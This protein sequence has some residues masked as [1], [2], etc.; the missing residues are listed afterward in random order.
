[1]FALLPVLLCEMP[2][3]DIFW[4]EHLAVLKGLERYHKKRA[5]LRA[6]A[7]LCRSLHAKRLYH[8]DLKAANLLFS[9]GAAPPDGVFNVIDLQGCGC[10]LMSACGAESKTWHN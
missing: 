4:Q 7:S 1:L 2:T 5:F 10:V 9:A 3:I 8:N 6:L